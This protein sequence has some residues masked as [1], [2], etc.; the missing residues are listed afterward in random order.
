MRDIHVPQRA[1]A[2]RPKMPARYR[3]KTSWN[4]VWLLLKM[5][6]ATE[7]SWSACPQVSGTWSC[8]W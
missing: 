5:D 4:H 7:T 2:G 8:L 6:T 1:V 3:D